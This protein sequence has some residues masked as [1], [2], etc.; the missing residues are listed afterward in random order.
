VRLRSEVCGAFS[1]S[2][3]GKQA[4]W[5]SQTQVS[6][7]TD[8]SEEGLCCFCHG[9][10]FRINLTPEWAVLPMPLLEFVAF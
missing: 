3:R 5:L 2:A 6:V 9:H 8:A 4:R 10:Y 7:Y 1:P